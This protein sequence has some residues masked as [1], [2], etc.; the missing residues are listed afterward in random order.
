MRQEEAADA[1]VGRIGFLPRERQSLLVAWASGTFD[2]A[3]DCWG[4]SL[5]PTLPSARR[6][7]PV[8]IGAGW[9][10]LALWEQPRTTGSDE[11][12]RFADHLT[13]IAGRLD[14]RA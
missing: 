7:A 14:A 8:R 13:V 6:P 4:W 9:P 10:G 3:V 12:R 5:G 11:W 1:D 2:A